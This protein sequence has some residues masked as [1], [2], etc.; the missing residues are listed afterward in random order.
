MRFWYWIW[1]SAVASI[2]VICLAA[3]TVEACT[4]FVLAKG[5]RVLAGNNEDYWN[6]NTRM[7][8]VPAEEGTYGRV[9]FGFDN[10]FPQGGM[11]DQGLFF[12]GFATAAKKVTKSLDKPRFQGLLLDEAMSKCGTVQDVVELFQK[13]N[14]AWLNKAMLFF[15]DRTGDSVIIEGDEFVRKSGA[16]QVVT[17]FYQSQI[18]SGPK[19]CE[20][21]E[22]AHR[23]LSDAEEPSIALC[24]QVLAAT[25]AEGKAVT[26]YSNV[27][28]LTKGVVYLYHFHNFENVVVIDVAKELEKGAHEVDIASLFPK[29]FAAEQFRRK[30]LQEADRRKASR[31]L[32]QPVANATLDEY[33]GRYK[34]ALES[35]G[36]RILEFERDGEKL[37]GKTTEDYRFELLPESITSFFHISP[38]GE[39]TIRF[40]RNPDGNVSKIICEQGGRTYTGSRID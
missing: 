29:T 1:W 37:F 30:Q 27:Y 23:M 6:T 12:D 22:I 28:D 24:R 2:L 19:P 4:G 16:F 13:Y 17:N 20:R 8:F 35:V 11:N 25:H 26:L 38:N 33:V 3:R 14:L 32:A 39:I 21:Y 34:I 5:N 40:A 36:E 9:Y 31:K 10:G 7:W 18:T 15:A